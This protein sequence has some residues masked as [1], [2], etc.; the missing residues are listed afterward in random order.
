MIRLRHV[1]AAM[2]FFATTSTLEGQV[3]VGT[4]TQPNCLPFGCEFTDVAQPSTYYQQVYASS[5]FGTAGFITGLDFFEDPEFAGDLNTMTFTISLST[6]T[7]GLNVDGPGGISYTDPDGNV[8]ADQT[9][10]GTYALSGGSAPATL[11][12]AGNPFFYDPAAGNLLLDLRVTSGPVAGS[13]NYFEAQDGDATDF[14][15]ATDFGTL[16]AGWGLVTQFDYGS[17]VAVTP[18]PGS[19]TLLGSGLAALVGVGARRRRRRSA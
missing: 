1:V 7:K 8:G 9:L 14:S 15:R 2:A 4:P 10:F 18:E 5:A 12:F 16:G 19:L 3:I 13:F 17:S 11:S 6:T